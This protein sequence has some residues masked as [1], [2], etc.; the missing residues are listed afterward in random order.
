MRG[1]LPRLCPTAEATLV[2]PCFGGGT[3]YENCAGLVWDAFSNNGW[4]SIGITSSSADPSTPAGGDYLTAAKNGGNVNT[5]SG[6]CYALVGGGTPNDVHTYYASF[7]R[8][9]DSP[10]PGA[11]T[12]VTASAGNGQA[13][14]SWTAPASNGGQAIENYVVTPYIGAVAQTPTTVGNVTST[15]IT[16]LAN[17]TTYTFK[18]AARNSFGTGPQSGSSNAVT[19]V[20]STAYPRPVAAS[21]LVLSLVP[22]FKQCVTSN[23]THA[24]PLSYGSCSPPEWSATS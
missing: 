19:P 10:F 4:Q 11:P 13:T 18:V 8:E 7:G 2:A 24:A 21:P 9:Q 14:V 3:S 12:G 6:A 22:A 1:Q 15:T 16:G 23:S 20:G 5:W 17:G